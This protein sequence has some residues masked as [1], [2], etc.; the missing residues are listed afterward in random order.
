MRTLLY[1]IAFAVLMFFRLFGQF[2]GYIGKG[3]VLVVWAVCATALGLGALVCVVV[4]LPIVVLKYFQE[5]FGVALSLFGHLMILPM[6]F[7]A[8]LAVSVM[9]LMAVNYVTSEAGAALSRRIERLA[10]QKELPASEE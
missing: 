8:F 1:G 5:G 6:E 9:L 4:G 2:M 10:F 7:C 3:V